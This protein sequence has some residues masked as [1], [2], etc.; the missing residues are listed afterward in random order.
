M[1]AH[2]YKWNLAAMALAV[3][4]I[5]I[6]RPVAGQDSV[7]AALAPYLDAQTIAVARVDLDKLNLPTVFTIVQRA[8]SQIEALDLD[9]QV[10][11]AL[12]S[13]AQ[14][15]QSDLRGAGC[16]EVYAV[17]RLSDLMAGELPY[18]VA[19]L[20]PGADERAI[21]GL[22]F[23]GRADG[24]TS[25][26]RQNRQSPGAAA[27]RVGSAVVVAGANVLASLE[28]IEPVPRPELLAALAAGADQPV[29]AAVAFND[30]QRRALRDSLTGDLPLGLPDDTGARLADD[31]QWLN[32][33]L[34][35]AAASPM[36][37]V[38]Q[39]RSNAAAERLSV[40]ASAIL[41][42]PS[43]PELAGANG[44]GLQVVLGGIHPTLN[45]DRL[46]A[47]LG[48]AVARALAEAIAPQL[49][50]SGLASRRVAC[51]N[52]LKQIS[53]AMNN[54]DSRTG[55]L[56]PPAIYDKDGK[57]LLSWR[58]A[59]L[60]DLDEGALYREF[61]LD[62]PWDSEHN[63]QLIARMP[64]VY[65]CPSVDVSSEG[66]TTY[67]VP[68]HAESAF[69]GGEGVQRR[70]IKDGANNTILAIEVASENAVV[71]TKPDD[72]NVDLDHPF[73]GLGG[74]HGSGFNFATVDGAV[75]FGRMDM[76]A[77]L[78]RGF[79]TRAGAEPTQF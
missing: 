23:S 79:V 37:L 45:G 61:H 21:A 8:T 15:L 53:L 24:P 44:S 6:A 40:L 39:G 47:S 29:Q 1:Q 25:R 54:Y 55:H 36:R 49:I 26:P 57:P 64:A 2:E 18:L 72:W 67:Q 52:K 41:Q 14:Q 33:G 74:E 65:A 71:W 51:A 22:L 77:S 60:R 63:R 78:L 38:V 70:D 76:Q 56:P 48:E 50:E 68:R 73:V 58:V 3:A 12:P 75:S 31:M 28:Q 69:P 11:A 62:E 5:F 9:P 42:I 46:T 10:V 17:M 16:H 34:G 4:L 27:R 19:P 13:I 30:D 20:G 35:S 59:L 32:L 43:R 66:R 7:G